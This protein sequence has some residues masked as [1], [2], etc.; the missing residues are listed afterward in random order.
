[1]TLPRK[2]LHTLPS[3][4]ALPDAGSNEEGFPFLLETVNGQTTVRTLYQVQGGSWMGIA[5]TPPPAQSVT[6]DYTLT[7]ADVGRTLDANGTAT[8]TVTVPPSTTTAFPIGAVVTLTNQVQVAAGDGVTIH[9][10]QG[11]TMLNGAYAVG[12]LRQVDTD[13]WLLTGQVTD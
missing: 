13:I 3:G 1:V 4:P 7:L 2:H 11:A 5:V 9:G 10:Y 8:L 6:G 12:Q